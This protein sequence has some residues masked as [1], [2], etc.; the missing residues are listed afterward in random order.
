MKKILF[1]LS[2]IFLLNCNAIGG[3]EYEIKGNIK[4]TT[5]KT[6]YLE[7][8]SHNEIK[9][10]DSSAI[11]KLGDFKLKG[12]I[13]GTGFYRIYL[14]DQLN[15]QGLSWFM[16]LDKSEKV[17]AVLD[18]KTPANYT[19]TST[20]AQKEFQDM[21]K[22]FNSQQGEIMQLY[23]QY[24]SISKSN[25]NSEDAQSISKLIQTKSQN[26][27]SYIDGQLKGSINPITKYYLFS[28][29]MEQMKTQA[30]NPDF[31]K[32]VEKFT[33]E[34]SKKLPNSIYSKDFQAITNNFKNQEKAA[35]IKSMLEVG[36]EA[37]DVEFLTEDGKKVKLSSFRGKTVLLDFW[38]SWCGPCRME[39]PN[40]VK[41]YNIFKNK[42]FTVVSVSQDSDLSKWKAAIAKDG[43]VWSNHFADRLINNKASMLYE[44][45]YIPKTYLIDKNGKIV[46]K[47]LR[48]DAL[49]HELEKLLK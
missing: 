40:V 35:E 17:A 22:S 10:V 11:S 31:I 36:A 6:I 7:K 9:I 34:L 27:N 12:N 26:L 4:N 20:P 23:Q 18:A 37:P 42:G 28:V 29:I 49:D 47:D 3:D 14:K 48:G 21:M 45:Q 8:M 15:P 32:E 24:Q 19:L 2:F 16:S 39:N 38:A 25:P 13:D 41:A 30:P 44:I 46:A 43:L 1:L 33:D 5:Q